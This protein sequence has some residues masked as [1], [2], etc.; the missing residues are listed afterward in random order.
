M[1]AS[2][3]LEVSSVLDHSDAPPFGDEAR[4][5]QE[6]TSA[7]NWIPEHTAAEM[8]GIAVSEV[9]EWIEDGKIRSLRVV[10]LS[11]V[12]YY[13]SQLKAIESKILASLAAVALETAE[14]V[15]LYGDKPRRDLPEKAASR[16]RTCSD[17]RSPFRILE[18]DGASS[19]RTGEKN[20]HQNRTAFSRFRRTESEISRSVAAEYGVTEQTI[21]R[22]RREQADATLPNL[23]SD[24]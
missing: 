2:K 13:A 5:A 16:Q 8:L 1:K 19:E 17:A 21:M 7:N 10:R 3:L 4:P 18:F 15:E 11:D 23:E 12:R 20:S 24:R 6:N 9:S 22:W 14:F